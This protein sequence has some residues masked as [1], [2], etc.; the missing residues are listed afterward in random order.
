MSEESER[1]LAGGSS[2]NNTCP[3][4]PEPLPRP[5]P[6][7]PLRTAYLQPA[8]GAAAAADHR[9]VVAARP[10]LVAPNC[11]QCSQFGAGFSTLLLLFFVVAVVVLMFVVSVLDDYD[12]D[13]GGAARN[14]VRL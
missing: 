7:R 6:L 1:K 8:L 9:S 2:N 3:L 4:L 11:A 5:A 14:K 13:G 10:Y 12:D